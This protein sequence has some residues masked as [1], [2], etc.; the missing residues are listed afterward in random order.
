MT[1]F[2]DD[3]HVILLWDYATSSILVSVSCLVSY[4]ILYFARDGRIVIACRPARIDQESPEVM[5]D[6]RVADVEIKKKERS[7]NTSCTET[8]LMERSQPA[9]VNRSCLTTASLTAY[10]L[11]DWFS[12]RPSSFNWWPTACVYQE[13]TWLQRFWVDPILS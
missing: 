12:G 10:F 6:W 11:I 7:T 5:E 1:F 9:K 4:W 8:H 3:T 2:D 13:W